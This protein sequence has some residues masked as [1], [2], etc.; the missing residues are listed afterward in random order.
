MSAPEQPQGVL[1]R[2]AGGEVY[3]VLNTV[4]GALLSVRVAGV[5]IIPL[6]HG[7]HAVIAGDDGALV[8]SATL[9]QMVDA[10]R[11]TREAAQ[12]VLAAMHCIAVAIDGTNIRTS[13]NGGAVVSNAPAKRAGKTKRPTKRA[14]KAKRTGKGRAKR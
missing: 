12:P 13:L 2:Y 1:L 11:M 9:S 14:G 6:L 7:P 3:G 5:D 4:P 8:T 10:Q